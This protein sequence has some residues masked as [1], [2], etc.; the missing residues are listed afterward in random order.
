MF[1][2]L[3]T[4]CFAGILCYASQPDVP[5]ASAERCLEQGAILSGLARA[6]LNLSRME[7]TS[8]VVCSDAGGGKQTVY[9]GRANAS[10]EQFP[11]DA[12]T[13]PAID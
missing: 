8:R 7:Q 4:T 11:D 1:H 13:L 2:L 12:M 9:I 10:P 5:Y 6:H 3:L